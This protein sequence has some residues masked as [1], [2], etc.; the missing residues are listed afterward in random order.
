MPFNM[1]EAGDGL[2]LIDEEWSISGR[3]PLGQVICRGL[4]YSLRRCLNRTQCYDLTEMLRHLCAA[5]DLVVDTADIDYWL[6]LEIDFQAQVTG[7]RPDRGA[8]SSTSGPLVSLL[9]VLSKARAGED[10]LERLAGQIDELNTLVRQQ[11]A[12]YDALQAEAEGARQTYGDAIRL[13]EGALMEAN[14]RCG[15]LLAELENTR[16]V[17]RGLI[18]STSWRL[19]APLR[20]MKTGLKAFAG[21]LRRG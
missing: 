17:C 8:V 14:A 20:A 16:D 2:Y 6:D 7:R 1:V 11:Q 4:V 18:S 15:A 13:R 21:G 3:I 10:Q 19:T 5:R 12:G 9:S